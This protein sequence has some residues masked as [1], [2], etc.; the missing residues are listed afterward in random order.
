MG[1]ANQRNLLP[2][3]MLVAAVVRRDRER[4]RAARTGNAALRADDLA[5]EDLLSGSGRVAERERQPGAELQQRMVEPAQ[6]SLASASST[7]STPSS[8]VVHATLVIDARSAAGTGCAVERQREVRREARRGRSRRTP[9]RYRGS[10]N[11]SCGS[12]SCC[13]ARGARGSSMPLAIAIGRH[14][15]RVAVLAPAIVGERLALRARHDAC[16]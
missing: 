14:S 3:C 5:D 13:P 1:I 15:A 4:R 10:R 11:G 2:R 16:E 8:P 9:G 6:L 7:P 12:S